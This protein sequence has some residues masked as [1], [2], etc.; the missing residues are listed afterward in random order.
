MGENDSRSIFCDIMDRFRSNFGS[1]LLLTMSSLGL[2]YCIFHIVSAD[3]EPLV[4][5]AKWF[6]LKI[7]R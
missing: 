5:A 3:L 1:L 7:L 2:S 6:P 4:H